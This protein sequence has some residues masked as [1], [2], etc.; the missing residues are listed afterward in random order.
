VRWH[1]RRDGSRVFI[2]GI[3]RPLTDPD[4]SVTGYVKVGQD[5]TERR[6]TEERLRESEA[7][8]RLMADAVPQIVWITDPDGRVEFFNK[9]WSDYT[10][11]TYQPETAAEV[12]ASFVH[13]DDGAATVAAFDEARATG[14]TFLVEHR[15]RSKTAGRPRPNCARARSACAS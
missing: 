9:Q 10:G 13:P 11:A 6:T 1:Q 7:R 12:A 5:V 15:I 3:V 4:G 2:E 14:G 8:F